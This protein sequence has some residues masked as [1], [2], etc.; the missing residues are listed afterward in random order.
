MGACVNFIPGSWKKPLGVNFQPTVPG[1]AYV[2]VTTSEELSSGHI[3]KRVRDLGPCGAQRTSLL[4]RT[5]VAHCM[6]QNA[7]RNSTEGASAKKLWR[8]VWRTILVWTAN[9]QLQDVQT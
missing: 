8:D 7:N 6:V 5:Y 1:S 4:K 2:G 3:K 9:Q